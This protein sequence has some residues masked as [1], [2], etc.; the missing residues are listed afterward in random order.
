MAEVRQ[1]LG[2]KGFL[3]VTSGTHQAMLSGLTAALQAVM[4]INRSSSR[5][6]GIGE[7][8]MAFVI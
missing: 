2:G 1:S 6:D 3:L 8:A 5:I 7:A 4:V